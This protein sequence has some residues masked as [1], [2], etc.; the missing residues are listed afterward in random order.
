[1]SQIARISSIADTKLFQYTGPNLLRLSSSFARQPNANLFREV[2]RNGSLRTRQATPS[3]RTFQAVGTQ[4]SKGATMAAITYETELQSALKAVRLASKL[5]QVCT[6]GFQ[7]VIFIYLDLAMLQRVSWIIPARASAFLKIPC[8]L[9]RVQLQLK[10]GEK[11]DKADDSPV[12][13]ADYGQ[14]QTTSVTPSFT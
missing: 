7:H 8:L 6:E 1:M 12:T 4:A 2:V 13:I 3:S 14:L 10:S 11:T 5:C 9:Q